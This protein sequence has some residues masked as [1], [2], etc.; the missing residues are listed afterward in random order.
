MEAEQNNAPP[1]NVPFLWRF[2]MFQTIKRNKTMHL[3][4]LYDVVLTY[5]RNKKGTCKSGTK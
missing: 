4:A 5:M 3:K 2:W 1:K